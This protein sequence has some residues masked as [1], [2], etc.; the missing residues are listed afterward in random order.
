[1]NTAEITLHRELQIG[2]IDNR[3]YGAFMGDKGNQQL[4]ASVY[5]RGTALNVNVQSPAYDD[6]EFDD[7]P[8]LEAVATLDAE[9]ETLTIFAVNRG[10]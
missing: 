7:V 9:A 2:D 3:L 10:E 8:Y 4:H 1:L 5:G 6:S